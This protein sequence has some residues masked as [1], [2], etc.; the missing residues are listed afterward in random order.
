MFEPRPPVQLDLTAW[1]RRAASNPTLYRQ[2]QVTEIL[3]HA[4]AIAPGFGGALFLKG[5]VLM[6]V[7][8]G[9]PRNTGDVDFTVTGDPEEVRRRVGLALDASFREAAVR[10]GYPNI[11]CRVQRVRPRPRPD[12]F[13]ASPFPAL[14]IT[15][16]SAA[17]DNP[18]EVA[19]LDA[20]NAARV[21]RIDLSFREPVGS[22]QKLV[23]GGGQEVQAYGLY[24]LVAEKLRAILQQIV[25]PHPG[26]RRQDVY[27]I[28]R[29]LETFDL[30]PQERAAI[31]SILLRKSREREFEPTREMISD[32]RI[33][34]KL[35]A[36]WPTL[37]DELD[38]P[39][40]DF[41][42][43]FAVVRGFYESLPWSR[44]EALGTGGA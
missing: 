35:R 23:V 11:L 32:L 9:S 29:L 39:L 20:G 26:T 4:V 42:A 6:A 25:R 22:V 1:V 2:R 16:G 19:R 31:H 10:A 30:D 17:R 36:D 27:D 12:T 18:A 33:E 15:V 7:A 13:A 43:C 44:S 34:A 28:A 40:P 41:D 24:D 37:A 3:L 38:E 14:E 8:Y 21:V 5:G